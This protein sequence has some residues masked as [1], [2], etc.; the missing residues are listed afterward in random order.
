MEL[1]EKIK[2]LR[3]ERG[4]S[5]AELAQKLGVHISHVS[6]LEKGRYSP[7]LDVLK[8]LVEA[9]SVPPDFFLYGS[10]DEYG[11]MELENKTFF[12]KMKM[13][14]DLDESDRVIIIGVIDAF[15]VK[16]RIMQFVNKEMLSA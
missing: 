16:K 15:L 5:Q 10:I 8:K 3:K 11:N 2:K 4:W 14:E 9:F 6:K 12:E 7:S 1:H 13:V